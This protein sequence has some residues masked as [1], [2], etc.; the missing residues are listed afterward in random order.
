MLKHL[1]DIEYIAEAVHLQTHRSIKRRVI[2]CFNSITQHRGM[3]FC[4]PNSCPG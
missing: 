4:G 3:A 1:V 2:A